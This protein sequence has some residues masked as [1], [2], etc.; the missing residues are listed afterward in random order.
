MSGT[1]LDG[2]D[3][4]CVQFNPKE[5]KIGWQWIATDFIPYSTAWREKLKQAHLISTPDLM[6]LDGAY[7]EFLGEKVNQF[8]QQNQLHG[9]DAIASHGHTIFHQ[10]QKGFT[11]QIG[12]GAYLQAQTNIPVICDFRS[13]DVALGGQGAPLVPIGDQLLFSEYDACINLGGFANISFDDAP[14]HRVAF[15]IV[16]VNY[17]LNYFAADLGLPYDAEGKIAEKAHIITDLL[18]ALNNLAYYQQLGPK[19]LGREWVEK[20]VLGLIK[21]DTHTAEDILA[22]FTAHAA[23]QISKVINYHSFKKVLFSGGGALNTFLM[24]TIQTQ[25]SSKIMIADDEL[26]HFKEALV[27]ALLGYLKLHKQ[28]NILQSVTGASRDSCAGVVYE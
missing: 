16:P 8:I 22:T 24:Q 2:L 26:L 28:T 23:E 1:S 18:N 11:L 25:T 21:N 9:I 4:A 15:D 10:P 12:N 17:V 5:N 3:L 20:E 19:S 7:G 27:F 13:Q 6:A 14:Q